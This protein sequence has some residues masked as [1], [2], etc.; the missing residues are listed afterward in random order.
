MRPVPQRVQKKNVQAAELT[1]RFFR[2]IAEIGEIGGGAEAVAIDFRLAM[3]EAHRVKTRAEKLQ[4]AVDLA[5]LHLGQ[6]GVIRVGIKY[7]TKN[8]LDVPQCR[9]VGV[10]RKF[11]RAA[12]TQ[13][14]NIV[15]P[16]DVVGVRVGINDR[17]EAP[18]TGAQCLLAKIGSC[19][20]QDRKS[21]V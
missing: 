21:V 18:H 11:F 2:N 12:E 19:I 20:N 10:E 15:E 5:Q 8:R 16:H 9:F 17:I 7:V 14:T 1:Q 6:S 3:L 4:S 13:G